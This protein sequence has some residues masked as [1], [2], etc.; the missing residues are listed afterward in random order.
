MRRREFIKLI[1]GSAAAWPLIARAQ[2]S[3]PMRRI[4]MLMNRAA[5]SA[6]G[7][8]RVAAF[9]QSLHQLGWTDGRDVRIDIRW[10]EDKIDLER[11]Y[12]AELI[13]L[14][15]EIVFASGTLSVIALQG[16][17]RTLPIVFVGVTDP[18]GASLVDSLARPG[19]NATGFMIYEYSFGGKR[20][21]LLKQVAPGVTHVAVLRD[22]SNPSGSAEFAAIQALA[23]SLKIDVSPVDTRR[24]AGE[25]E[26]AITTFART[27]NGGLIVTPNASASVHRDLIVALAARHRLPAVYPFRY[28]ADGGGLV[29]YGPDVVD[30]CRR[31]AG[32]VDRILKGEKPADLPV[33]APTKY[34]MV[35]N[36]KTAKALGLT[37]SESLIARAD[38]VIE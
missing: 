15:P 8:A 35:I 22:P 1:G 6:E 4:G 5:E 23:Q 2:Q 29:S 30:Q 27:A 24:D 13:A 26:R 33:Q 31:A 16:T 37:L 32:Y 19:G 28:H 21:E 3:E 34:E 20:L 36:L 14:G 25:I 7:Q 18:V 9:T 38:E 11:K 12:A 10:G 17:S